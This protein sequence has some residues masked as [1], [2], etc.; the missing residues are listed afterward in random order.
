MSASE[1][2]VSKFCQVSDYTSLHNYFFFK[3]WLWNKLYF[4]WAKCA[5]IKS[6]LLY[7]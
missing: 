5:N 3:L 6:T 7:I 4:E 1:E 2:Q